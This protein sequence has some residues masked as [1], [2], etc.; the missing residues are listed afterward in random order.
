MKYPPTVLQFSGG[1]DS[2]ACLHLLRDRWDEIT[3]AW[4]NTG[5]AFPETLAQMQKVRE[6]VP[7][8]LEI[9]GRQNIALEGYPADVLPIHMTRYAQR[10]EGATARTFQNRYACCNAGIFQ[11]LAEAMVAIGAKTIIRGQKRC[12]RKKSTVRH[13]EVI[14][15]IRYEF[16]IDTWSDD[17]VFQFL[18]DNHIE[19]PS[20]YPLMK[21]GLD[22]WN[23]TAYLDENQGKLAYLAR[24]MPAEYETVVAILSDLAEGIVDKM[25]R[26][27]EL[28]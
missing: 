16:P 3:V 26:H 8:F 17:H 24:H 11:P 7:H 22:C 27:L 5:A 14:E 9:H 12:D 10:F 19:T 6:M 28:V 4:V 18:V 21:T 1:K 2:L 25:P 23:C 13:G 20:N 15:G